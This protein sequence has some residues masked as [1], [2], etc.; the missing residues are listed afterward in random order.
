MK[1]TE[2]SKHRFQQKAQFTLQL[3]MKVALLV[4]AAIAFGK[5]AIATN[6]NYTNATSKSTVMTTLSNAMPGD[7][8]TLADGNYN[9]WTMTFNNTHGTSTSNWIVFRS[10]TIGGVV[11]TGN[12]Y[13]QFS[14][15]RVSIEGF[16]FANGNAGTAT[17]IKFAS[18]GSAFYSRVTDVTIDNFNSATGVKNY[19]VAIQGKYNRLDHCT[20]INKNNEAPTIAIVYDSLNSLT[21]AGPSTY[22]RIDSNYFNGRSFQGSNGGETIRLGDSYSCRTNGYNTVEYNLF[23]N[24]TAAE[25]E[26]VSN[27]SNYNTYRY[28]TFRNYKGGLTLRHGRYCTVNG[29]MFLV[30][31]GTTSCYGLRVFD[32]GHK[33]F[34]NYMEG[35]NGNNNSL[36]TAR[37]PINLSNGEVDGNANVH[38][39]TGGASNSGLHYPAD[40]C[41]VAFNTVVNCNGGGGIVIGYTSNG[42]YTHPLQNTIIRYNIVKMTNGYSVYKDTVGGINTTLTFTAKGNLYSNSYG[43]IPTTIAGFTGYSNATYPYGTRDADSML[44]APNVVKDSCVRGDTIQ[45]GSTILGNMTYNTLLGNKDISLKARG[46]VYD[47]GCDEVVNKVGDT[48][49][50][51]PLIACKVGAGAPNCPSPRAAIN[52]AQLNAAQAG[53]KIY[54]NPASSVINVA[55]GDERNVQS[56]KLVN[57]TGTVVADISMKAFAN[58][59]SIPVKQYPAGLYF[60]QVVR[61]NK[62]RTSYP[63]MVSK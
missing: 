7:T 38:D 24:G 55:I 29:N 58:I 40:S 49:I 14:G 20:F 47:V 13:L 6:Y 1:R 42:E 12:S 36:T 19:W 43:L 53:I 30:N 31:N 57:A 35:L 15:Y 62:E 25:P 2:T 33:V 60:V 3:K 26:I 22:H 51:R 9:N 34:N 41:L 32:R 17:V 50:N 28:N 52:L 21:H 46:S 39:S 45:I 18:S 23:E 27:K 11:F 56:I 44:P 63:V 4:I 10:A 8:I 48:T 54:P 59:V 37:C 16:K 61:S 5:N